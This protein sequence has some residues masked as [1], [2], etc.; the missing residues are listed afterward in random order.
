MFRRRRRSSVRWVGD[1]RAGPVGLLLRLGIPAALVIGGFVYLLNAA[2]KV[3]PQR[4][5]VR[6]EVPNALAD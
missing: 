2:D 4:Q 5:E 3:D 6:I 1:R